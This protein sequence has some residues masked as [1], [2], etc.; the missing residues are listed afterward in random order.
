MIF[1]SLPK[2]EKSPQILRIPV[3]IYVLNFQVAKFLQLEYAPG[4]IVD[5]I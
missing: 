2:F 4:N 3:K 5:C 1:N